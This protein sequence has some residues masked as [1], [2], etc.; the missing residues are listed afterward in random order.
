M[1]AAEGGVASSPSS[2]LSSE[3][4]RKQRMDIEI[5][6]LRFANHKL[7]V[8]NANLKVKFK[9]YKNEYAK[10][11]RLA[12]GLLRG[13]VEFKQKVLERVEKKNRLM[14]LKKCNCWKNERAFWRKHA[15]F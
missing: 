12:E 4:L 10:S 5:R 8:V 15:R 7:R 3:T 13:Q 11:F 1:E 14:H 9:L 2:L 6:K